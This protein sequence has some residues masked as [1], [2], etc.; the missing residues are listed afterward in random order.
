MLKPLRSLQDWAHERPDDLAV[1]GPELELSAGEL[2]DTA[3][4]ILAWIREAGVSTQETVGA[5]VP[6]SL[7]PAFLVALLARGGIG[8]LVNSQAEVGLDVPLQRLITVDGNGMKHPADV[9]LTFDDSAIGRLAQVDTSTVDIASPAA[10]DICW[11][12]YSSGTTGAPKAVMRTVAAV[13]ALAAPRRLRLARGAYASLQPGT[14]AGSMSAF[15]A[16]ITARRPH[17]AAGTTEENLGMLRD[18]AIEIAE[19]SP[20]QL[21]RLLTVARRSGDRL[22]A[23]QELHSAGAPLS[24]GLA[25]ALADWFGV[26]VYDGYGSSETGFVAARRADVPEAPERG[27]VVE[28][29]VDVEIVDDDHEP[30]PAGEDGR[31]RLRTASMGVGY[32]GAPDLGEHKGFHG[33]WFYPGDL[34]RLIDGELVIIGREDDLMNVGGRKIM[35]HRVEEIVLEQPGVREAVACAVVDKLGI[36]Q[37]AIAIVGEPIN[38]P[39]KFAQKL[40]QPLG[41]IL[42]SLIMRMDAIPRSENGKPQRSRVI[43]ILQEQLNR[44]SNIL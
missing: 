6:P 7:H 39:V 34:G 37:L 1:A 8:S 41:G 10:D 43:D 20:F 3:L 27:G 14:V 5:A 42:P 35:P 23:L 26:R 30:V 40:R 33:G 17:L 9:L 36:R 29:G 12:I 13:E 22:P 32:F 16:A 4:R 38:D 15:L 18:R 19:G 11:F 24:S 21:D 44:P 2:W 28:D 31:V 25:S